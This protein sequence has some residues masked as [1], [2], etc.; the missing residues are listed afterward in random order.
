MKRRKEPSDVWGYSHGC[1][2]FQQCPLCY[3][4]RAYDPSYIKCRHCEEDAKRHICN[5]EKHTEKILAKMIQR[6]KI[7]LR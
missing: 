1:L 6:Q 4:C 3:G 2:N 5:R 7:F